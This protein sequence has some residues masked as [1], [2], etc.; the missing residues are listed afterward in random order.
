MIPWD[1][2]AVP[3][4]RYHWKGKKNPVKVCDN[5]FCFDIETSSY[6]IQED[7][8]VVTYRT[9]EK[10]CRI[11]DSR[12]RYHAI[13][14]RVATM[15]KGCCCYLWQFGIDDIRMYGRDLWEF[16]HFFDQLCAM[17]E[18]PF[19]LYVHNLS[20]EYQFLRGIFGD[21]NIEAFYTE[22]RK[23][24]YIKY[25]N[26]EFRCTYRL[27]NSSLAMWGKKLNLPKLDTL[28]Y[29][30]LYTPYSKLPQGALEYSERDIEIMH[31]GLLKYIA[32]YGNVWNIPY[33]QTGRVRG[34]IKSLYHDNWNYHVRITDSLPVDADEYKVQRRVFMGGMCFS[35]IENSGKILRRVGSYDRAS[36]YPT[37]MVLNPFPAGRF[38]ETQ[39]EEDQFDF[40]QYHYIFYA[41][42]SNVEAKTSI[43]CIP[44]SRMFNKFGNGRYNNGKLIDFCGSFEMFLTEVDLQIYR[45]FY[46]FDIYY[47]KVWVA[48]SRLLDIDL[49]KYVL[50][51]YAKKTVLK[52]VED[53]Q[54]EY[55][56]DK[57][58]LNAIYGC[59]VSSLVY[60][61]H[62]LIDNEWIDEPLLD[63][64][65][66]EALQKRQDCKWKNILS[67]HTGVYVTAYQRRDLLQMVAR[68]NPSDF[69]YTDTDSIKL[70]KP[71]LYA[72]LFKEENERIEAR[73]KEISDLRGIPEEAFRPKDQDGKEHLI[74]LWENEGIYDRAVFLGS[75]RYCYEQKDKKGK[76]KTHVVVSGVPKAAEE[77]VKIKDFK[78][79]LIFTPE[80][81]DY[82]K[83]ILFYL[84]GNN[85][86]VTVNKGKPDS[87]VCNT[88]YGVAMYP[89]G[90]DMSLTREY[91]DLIE[92]Y[93]NQKGEVI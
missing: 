90:Y 87:Y 4:F 42:F 19:I 81:V 57:E 88:P 9:I 39:L 55:M 1:L 60:P 29:G 3:E 85:P 12:E 66:T 92:L 40:S 33:T 10:R 86:Q 6:L 11:K 68:I 75:K 23:P 46:D 2:H 63:D 93:L 35:G 56:R 91:K 14:D 21:D 51:L 77:H 13:N 37:E 25:K 32:E 62:K 71:E 82:K 49:V 16:K 65:V 22:A 59:C 43:S 38:H 54:N 76:K 45:Q 61:E 36:A 47:K 17:I 48:I 72:H 73:V 74:G 18:T 84:D 24:L 30:E 89:T 80:M 67:Y 5:V 28:D 27:T 26:A 53:R 70:L 15:K 58:M 41:E 44:S 8:Q 78:D 83:S 20:Y 50:D 69:C 31:V 64:I 34:D 52:G 7:G 79:G